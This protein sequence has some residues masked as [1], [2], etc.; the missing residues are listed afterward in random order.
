MAVFR[1]AAD[2]KAPIVPEI[3]QIALHSTIKRFPLYATI[4]K[5]GMFWHYLDAVH[6]RYVVERETLRP[7]APIRMRNRKDQNFRVLYYGH[8]ISLEVFH[9]VSDGLGA[10]VFM[11]NLLA[12]YLRLMGYAKI[13]DEQIFSLSE[14]PKPHELI[15]AFPL[16]DRAE[17]TAGYGGGIALE[18]FGK[19]R[20]KQFLH[21]I[22]PTSALVCAA[23]ERNTTVTGFILSAIFVAAKSACKAKPKGTIKIQVPVNMRQYYPI[24]TLK[25][26][27]MFTIVNMRY[28]EIT[29]FDK[30]IP[31]IN[32]KLKDETSKEAM[33]RM[34]T[35]TNRLSEN[36]VMRYLP[37]GFKSLFIRKFI[38]GIILKHSQ[39]AVFTNLGVIKTNFYD[40]VDR[41]YAITGASAS[42]SVGCS[43][44]T[45]GKTAVLTIAKSVAN[46]AFEAKLYK[47]LTSANLEI[48][49]EGNNP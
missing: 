27:S 28:D 49:I 10:M 16:T 15:N 43:M 11:K 3:L 47:I 37:C 8:R 31:I 7:C 45:Y 41:L 2:M 29:E 48:Q 35:T 5:R 22:M 42:K 19:K 46:N 4:V 1:L 25:N 26:F 12:E 21:F 32:Q 14:K 13:S 44:I 34:A 33:D 18:V 40:A 6:K 20:S 38:N 9:C 23:K 39:T 30:I 36:A 17:N 24:Q